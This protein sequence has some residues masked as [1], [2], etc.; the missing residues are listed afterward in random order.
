MTRKA[1]FAA[2]VLAVAPASISAQTTVVSEDAVRYERAEILAEQ[3]MI[4]ANQKADYASAASYLRDAASLWGTEPASVDALLNAGRFNYY[5]NRKLVA[6]SAL[7][8][9]GETAEKIGDVATAS[10]AYR[11]AAWV[12]AEAGEINTA[13]ELLARGDRLLSTVA[14]VALGQAASDR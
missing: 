6:V 5:A 10:R 8:T 14:I 4:L 3:A 7:K 9:A 12:A 1:L 11:D 2:A 13:V